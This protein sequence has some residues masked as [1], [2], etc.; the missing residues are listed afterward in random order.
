VS[1]PPALI[2]ML[3]FI[4]FIGY[5]VPSVAMFLPAPSTV[6]VSTKQA[7]LAAWQLFP[8]YTSV[9]ASVCWYLSAFLFGDSGRSLPATLHGLRRTYAFALACAVL[10][11]I[12]A[13]LLSLM[14]VVCPALFL[15]NVA[16]EFHP[17]RVFANTFPW[18]SSPTQVT[19]VG[20]GALWFL[21]WD[22]VIGSSALLL[23][24]LALYKVAH[25]KASV[26]VRW[27]ELVWKIAVY[28]LVFGPVG[29]A[30]ALMWERDEFIFEKATRLD[31]VGHDR[32]TL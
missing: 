9:L 26:E 13:W 1:I 24:S 21:Q 27:L 10:P 22:D 32:K 19:S 30:V 17:L 7:L 14:S 31:E 12:A 16:A 2:F 23:W 15:E 18:S 3:P 5:V 28:S 25:Q 6:T 20:E 11:R 4:V 8:V 29:S